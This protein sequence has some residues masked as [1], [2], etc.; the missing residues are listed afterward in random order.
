MGLILIGSYCILSVRKRAWRQL[1]FNHANYLWLSCFICSF[2][3]LPSHFCAIMFISRMISSW[4]KSITWRKNSLQ[5]ERRCRF[6]DRAM[7]SLTSNLPL[8]CLQFLQGMNHTKVNVYVEW[9]EEGTMK[10]PKTAV[11]K[12][13]WRNCLTM[14]RYVICVCKYRYK[15]QLSGSATFEVVTHFSE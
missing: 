7:A 3:L 6:S 9:Q 1:L 11:K 5:F 14:Y 15:I 10:L 12:N 13:A 8:R 4:T 2:Q